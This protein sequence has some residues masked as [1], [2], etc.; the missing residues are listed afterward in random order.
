MIDKDRSLV[1]CAVQNSLDQ[2]T[3]VVVDD[4]RL[5]EDIAIY[6]DD[7][8]EL[9]DTYATRFGVDMSHYLWRTGVSTIW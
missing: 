3:G 4:T 9:L 6:G 8:H 1:K 2:D 5:A 7:F